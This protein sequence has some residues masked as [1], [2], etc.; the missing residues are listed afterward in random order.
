MGRMLLKY[1]SGGAFV[2][3]FVCLLG[4]FGVCCCFLLLFILSC[5]C[6]WV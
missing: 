3:F 5:H 6:V 1:C 4:F 2:C